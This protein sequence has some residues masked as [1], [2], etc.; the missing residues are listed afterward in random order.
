MILKNYFRL[1]ILFDETIPFVSYNFYNLAMTSNF[2]QR[3]QG[4]ISTIPKEGFQNIF[5]KNKN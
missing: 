1:D 2:A 4:K 5:K 3:F